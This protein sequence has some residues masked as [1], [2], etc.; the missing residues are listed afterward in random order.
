MRVLFTQHQ[1]ERSHC[2]RALPPFTR[3][4]HRRLIGHFLDC[5]YRPVTFSTVRPQC[6]DLIVRHDVDLSL[7]AA[8][9]IAELEHDV[10][11]QATYFVMVSNNYYNIYSPE[12]QRLLARL[13]ELRHHI[14]L[15]FDWVRC[16]PDG[17]L[18]EYCAAVEHE[19][20]LLSAIVPEPTETISFHNPRRDLVNRER[21]PGSPPHTYEPRFFTEVAY[22]PDSGGEWRFGGP[23][24]H[25]A[26]A[27]GTAIQLLTHPIWW[28]HDEPTGGPA[29]TL[30]KFA[31]TYRRHLEAGCRATSAPIGISCNSGKC[32]SEDRDPGR[33]SAELSAVVRILL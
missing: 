13:R 18:A 9:N 7:E 14:G 8:V 30:K 4:G 22:I 23:F 19:M 3:D 24:G 10:G 29:S 15:H 25:P 20:R 12:G 6:R 5:G 21:P 32:A 26:F 27:N 28:D 31:L 1:G 33:A 2:S 16:P 11:I 17:S